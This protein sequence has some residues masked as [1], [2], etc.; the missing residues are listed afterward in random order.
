MSRSLVACFIY[1]FSY[2]PASVTTDPDIFSVCYKTGVCDIFFY[3]NKEYWH[4]LPKHGAPRHDARKAWLEN[5]T[6]IKQPVETAPLGPAALN[7]DSV[8]WINRT[9]ITVMLKPPTDT[10]EL[11]PYHDNSSLWVNAT[12]TQ[13]PGG[14]PYYQW[15]AHGTNTPASRVTNNSGT[16]TVVKVE[17]M[18]GVPINV[19][20]IVPCAA[21]CECPP[22]YCM[23]KDLT[24]STNFSCSQ[25]NYR[26]GW[27]DYYP[28]LW[29]NDTGTPRQVLAQ[30]TSERIVWGCQPLEVE[31]CESKC[32]G[33]DLSECP[34][35]CVKMLRESDYFES[36]SLKI[37]EYDYYRLDVLTHDNYCCKY[38]KHCERN[39]LFAKA[40]SCN[41]Y[42]SIYVDVKPF[43]SKERHIWK[44]A[45]GPLSGFVEKINLPVYYANYY[46]SIVGEKDFTG[47]VNVTNYNNDYTFFFKSSAGN[48]Q[49]NKQIVGN[50]G[51]ISLDDM[52]S[53]DPNIP[54]I[55]RMSLSFT[56][57]S[58]P[59]MRPVTYHVYYIEGLAAP[60]DARLLSN[61][62][63][64]SC[65]MQ[66]NGI[67]FGKIV[68]RSFG[69]AEGLE[70]YKISWVIN[71]V[72]VYLLNI[73]A[74]NDVGIGQPYVTF[75]SALPP[76]MMDIIS[77][78]NIYYIAGGVGLFIIVV[79]LMIYFGKIKPAG[80]LAAKCEDNEKRKLIE[81]A[82]NETEHEKIQRVRRGNKQ[83]M[84]EKLAFE[85]GDPPAE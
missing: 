12:C 29:N 80:D 39:H 83:K 43:P 21:S 4:L 59:M 78:D 50:S 62:L 68:G 47:E 49:D 72:N 51:K 37:G 52:I 63:S 61:T 14:L 7:D 27:E 57:M 75:Q 22:Q 79:G 18:M 10:G 17:Y 13:T 24:K 15:D 42:V 8:V 2:L 74:E 9:N 85:N 26:Q 54:D 64:S 76:N 44:S 48:R 70:R 1:L 56:G 55:K 34:G 35:H 30:N 73:Y 5:K 38:L 33:T 66:R 71:Q 41:G 36:R 11:L 40:E 28:L 53:E 84:A 58:D 19:D 20:E 31:P 60:E 82:K 25:A 32:Q 45:Q 67:Y 3:E 16:C 23:V 6:T 65:T 46:I 81:Q 77:G 69:T